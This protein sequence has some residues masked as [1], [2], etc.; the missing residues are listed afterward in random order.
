[1]VV[2]S[3][4]KSFTDCIYSTQRVF[5][6]LFLLLM[7]IFSEEGW[8]GW[9]LRFTSDHWW[10]GTFGSPNTTV[11]PKLSANTA[12]YYMASSVSG[13]DESNPVLWLTTRVSKMELSCPLGTT[14]PVPQEKFPRKPYDKS[15]IDQAC[16]VK[17]AGYWPCSFFT[18]LWTSTP[19]RSIDMQKKELGQYPAILTSHVVNNPY[20]HI[21]EPECTT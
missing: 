12:I 11:S 8:G 21:E 5:S 13:Q 3:S 18:S 14:R 7:A 16:S 20:V 6:P 17:T 15:F 10:R 9:V 4:I 19:S 1:M 2:W